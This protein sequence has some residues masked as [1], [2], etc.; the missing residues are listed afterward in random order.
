[1]KQRRLRDMYFTQQASISI[2][3]T[4]LYYT[5]SGG[6]VKGSL[7]P[8]AVSLIFAPIPFIMAGMDKIV[9]EMLP[10]TN[11]GEGAKR[12]TEEKGEFAQICYGEEARHIALFTLRP[13]FWRG[14]HYHEKK[15]ET[16][17]VAAGSVRGVFIDMETNERVEHVL[18]KGT[19][20]RVSPRCWHQGKRIWKLAN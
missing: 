5:A 18:G 13:G 16:F 6:S 7:Q 3:K 1:M 9:L 10:V 17:Y 14:M 12:W 2:C 11:E 4:V 15:A 20:L 8:Y 19:R